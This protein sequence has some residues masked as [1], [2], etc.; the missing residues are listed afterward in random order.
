MEHNS[1]HSAHHEVVIVVFDGVQSLDVS[2]PLEVWAG[3]A[4]AAGSRYRVRTASLGGASVRCSSG[5]GLV[6]SVALE[7][8]G[9]V[10]TLVVAGGEGAHHPDPVR[11]LAGRAGRVASVCS[12]A[13]VLAHAGVLEGRRA[14]T[15]WRHCERLAREFPGVEVERDPVFVR[16]GQVWTSAGVTSGIDLALA[17][18]EE[19]LG[20]Q[21]ALELARMLVVFLIRP[22]GQAQWSTQL[23]TQSAERAEVRQVQHLVDADPGQGWSLA[24]MA[25]RA[26]LSVR[27]FSRVFTAQVGCS[28]GRYVERVRV[29]WAR[30]RLEQ[31]SAP[32]AA[33]A[34]GCGFGTDEG[35][36]RAFVRVLGCAPS[37]YRERA[38]AGAV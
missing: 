24:Q 9:R 27:Q 32:V 29:E 38:G 19:D 15:H 2:G 25:E 10:D 36:R 5:L 13:F 37:H 6:P 22:A 4:H 7:Q 16:S 26:G 28:P 1:E 23:T 8:V 18:V 34:R 33:I 35:M 12:G 21:V 14:T 17:V 30:R 31:G 3:A 20:R 11:E